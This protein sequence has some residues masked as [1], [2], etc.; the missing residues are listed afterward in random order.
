M[1]RARTM[2]QG[3]GLTEVRMFREQQVER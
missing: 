1:I 3:I 2:A